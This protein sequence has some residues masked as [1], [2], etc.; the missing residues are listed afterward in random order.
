M[1]NVTIGL[2]VAVVVEAAQADAPSRME[3]GVAMS[4]LGTR[5][6]DMLTHFNRGGRFEDTMKKI[7][8]DCRGSVELLGEANG[9]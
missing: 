5:L 4:G 7:S 6:P 8:A 3:C 1:R 9:K 2:L